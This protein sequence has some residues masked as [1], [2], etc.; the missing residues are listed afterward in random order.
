MQHTQFM[1]NMR[2]PNT[3]TTAARRKHAL[4]CF[5]VIIREMLGKM[6]STFVFQSPWFAKIPGIFK[7]GGWKQGEGRM[8]RNLKLSKK[9]S[10]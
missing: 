2:K 5:C 6:L 4:Q 8:E 1:I 7:R 3:C 9:G 10:A